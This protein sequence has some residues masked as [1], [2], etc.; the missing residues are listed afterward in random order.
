MGL[1]EM[2]AEAIEESERRKKLF[3]PEV[4]TKEQT[5][6]EIG[7]KPGEFCPTLCA[8]DVS[9]C[10]FCLQKQQKIL[11]ALD[12]LRMQEQAM[13]H[14]SENKNV[15]CAFCSASYEKGKK[16]CPFCETPYPAELLLEELPK[17]DSEQERYILERCVE[18]YNQYLL[19]AEKRRQKEYAFV[20][21]GNFVSKEPALSSKNKMIANH[22]EQGAR[23]YKVGYIEYV[24]GV[25]SRKYET[26]TEIVSKTKY[27]T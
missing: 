17:D 26:L 14:P 5:G 15:S 25:M 7:E 19:W 24:A 3:S 8:L 11:D 9:E 2:L 1:K 12:E 23:H 13:G 22:V 16:T 21:K 27:Y 18:I 10:V 20:S 6:R 4:Y